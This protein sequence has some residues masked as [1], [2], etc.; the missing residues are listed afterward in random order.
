MFNRLNDSSS[1]S[2]EL[3]LEEKVDILAVA[4]LQLIDIS[5]HD[6]STDKEKY[7]HVQELKETFKELQNTVVRLTNT[8]LIVQDDLKSFNTRLNELEAAYFGELGDKK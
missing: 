5:N 7:K 1:P 4:V 2:T 6:V 3:L 8:Y